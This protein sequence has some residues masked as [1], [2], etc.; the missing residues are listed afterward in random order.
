MIEKAASRILLRAPPDGGRSIGCGFTSGPYQLVG[1]ASR[2]YEPAR[3]RCASQSRIWGVGAR[4]QTR[5]QPVE[6]A[7]PSAFMVAARRRPAV[8]NTHTGKFGAFVDCRVRDLDPRLGGVWSAA[9][10]EKA[11]D[12]LF[13]SRDVEKCAGALLF[14]AIKHMVAH[15]IAAAV[16]ASIAFCRSPA[17]QRRHWRKAASRMFSNPLK[18][19]PQVQMGVAPGKRVQGFESPSYHQ[20]IQQDRIL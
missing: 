12:G 16:T 8:A 14:G 19:R 1:M 17:K 2:L 3:R 9:S 15:T 11:Q 5:F 4:C 10:H 6:R 18:F 13:Q 20:S 7:R